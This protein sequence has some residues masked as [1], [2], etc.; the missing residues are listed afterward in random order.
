MCDVK[1]GNLLD[2]LVTRLTKFSEN[3]EVMVQERTQEY[4]QEKDRA[5]NLLYAIIPR[6]IADKLKDGE[7]IAA[8][9]FDS[10]TIFFSG[11]RS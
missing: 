6:P 11:A 8:E 3:L 1:S 9:P 10:V 5:D 2:N 4:L 7:K